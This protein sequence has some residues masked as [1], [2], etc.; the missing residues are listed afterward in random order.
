M[1]FNQV[2]GIGVGMNILPRPE[3]SKVLPPSSHIPGVVEKGDHEYAEINDKNIASTSGGDL[4]AKRYGPY[5]L[6]DNTDPGSSTQNVNLKNTK[7]TATDN[8][9]DYPSFVP[10]ESKILD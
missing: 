7:H 2:Q 5:H 6:Y 8:L 9:Y 1:G 3:T 4:E 10:S